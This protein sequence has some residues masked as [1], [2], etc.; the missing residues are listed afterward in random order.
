MIFRQNRY[1]WVALK[2]STHDSDS[3]SNLTHQR[4][5]LHEGGKARR[6]YR[7][8]RSRHTTPFPLT[9]RPCTS[10]RSSFGRA[11]DSIGSGNHALPVRVQKRISKQ[12]ILFRYETKHSRTVEARQVPRL[13]WGYQVSDVL[14]RI[15]SMSEAH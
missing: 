4:S 6:Y 13:Y 2:Q 11:G 15:I 5:L 7:R 8:G 10:L 12:V 1:T 14:Q 9:H 3:H